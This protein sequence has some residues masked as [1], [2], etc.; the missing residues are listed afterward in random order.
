MQ[1]RTIVY[2]LCLPA[3]VMSGC[4]AL[5][6]RDDVS[7]I[8]QS[9]KD[10]KLAVEAREH[11]ACPFPGNL[12]PMNADLPKNKPCFYALTVTD[13]SGGKTLKAKVSE[14]A[15]KRIRKDVNVSYPDF[16]H[17]PEYT[18]VGRVPAGVML[19]NNAD[20]DFYGVEG[21]EDLSCETPCDPRNTDLP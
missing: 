5:G 7:D 4:Q 10:L 21:T 15:L 19:Q 12:Q 13:T 8:K 6:I 2:L 14:R 1:F 3:L 11:A 16:A 9:I 20:Y 17:R 18:F